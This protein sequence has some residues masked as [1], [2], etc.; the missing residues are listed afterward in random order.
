MTESVWQT[1]LQ[2]SLGPF[3]LD[4]S[5]EAEIANAPRNPHAKDHVEFEWMAEESKFIH[6]D[7]K[8]LFTFLVIGEA[9]I[10]KKV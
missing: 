1:T 5:Q 7:P 2:S 8:C 6:E 3:P 10:Y 4:Q 9:F